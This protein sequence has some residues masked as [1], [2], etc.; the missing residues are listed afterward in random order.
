MFKNQGRCKVNK[1]EKNVLLLGITSLLNDVSSEMISAVLPLFISQLGG[2][3][4]AIG[5]VGGLRELLSNLLKPLSGYLSDSFLRKKPLVFLGYAVSSFFKLLIGLSKN[6]EQVVFSSV[7]ERVGKGIRTAPRDSI[8]SLSGKSGKSFGIHRTMDTAGAL[9][10]V[11]L[12][13]FLAS[14]KVENRE[15]IVSA[16]FISFLSLLPILMVK[17]PEVLNRKTSETLVKKRFDRKF[18]KLLSVF[19]IYSFGSVSF[20]F[21]IFIAEKETSSLTAVT[22]YALLNLS[23][24]L[25]SFPVGELSDRVGRRFP[26]SAGYFLTALSLFILSVHS[27]IVLLTVSFLLYGL[28]LG[29]TDTVQRAL[30]ADIVGREKRGTAYGLFHGVTGVGALLGNLLAGYLWNLYG[31][32][33]F[34]LFG[35]FCVI[36]TILVSRYN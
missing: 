13:L 10:G 30:T 35:I 33:S 26:L 2:G 18:F 15:I 3:G 29:I 20:M 6:V 23:Y 1:G 21:L 36:A 24:L 28:A 7:L 12:V 9:I 31:N 22:L 34:A 19:A 17:E 25:V 8:I 32:A 27:G 14:L 16:G 4:V 5:V 11:I